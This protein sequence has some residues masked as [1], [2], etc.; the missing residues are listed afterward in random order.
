M[1]NA[2]FV[3][4]SCHQRNFKSNV[5]QF[6]TTVKGNLDPDIVK[7]SIGNSLQPC[8]FRIIYP[9]EK[10]KLENQDKEIFTSQEKL[11]KSKNPHFKLYDDYMEYEERCLQTDPTGYLYTFIEEEEDTEKEDENDD[12]PVSRD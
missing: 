2:V 1:H 5:V 6:S 4:I 12:H 8:G 9:H 10:Y 7:R 11:R 3:C